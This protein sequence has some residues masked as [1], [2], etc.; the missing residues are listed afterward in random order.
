MSLNP[1]KKSARN[2]FLKFQPDNPTD[3]TDLLPYRAILLYSS[4]NIFRL[5]AACFPRIL[6]LW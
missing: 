1:L 6:N 4:A 5:R 3:Q 2:R